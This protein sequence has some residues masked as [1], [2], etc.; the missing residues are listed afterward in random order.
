[1]MA[2]EVIPVFS[3]G[4]GR[5]YY[6]VCD[7]T[8]K[9]YVYYDIQYPLEL[10]LAEAKTDKKIGFRHCLTCCKNG[11]NSNVAM[12]LCVNCM[13]EM[14]IHE[15]YKCHSA[16]G[17]LKSC[18]AHCFWFSDLGIYA[19]LDPS[20]VELCKLHQNEERSILQFAKKVELDLQDDIQCT[21]YEIANILKNIKDVLEPEDKLPLPSQ[22]SED[23]ESDQ[24]SDDNDE[25]ENT[26]ETNP[27]E[28][29]FMDTEL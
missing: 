27:S 20:T 16:N 8:N 17:T 2:T 18:G 5:K 4:K 23:E 22:S 7:G 28:S 14:E 26:Q 21:E 25:E 3:G 9:E 10:A 6:R 11:V 29:V 13:N 12:I 1:M 15:K 19:G 24:E